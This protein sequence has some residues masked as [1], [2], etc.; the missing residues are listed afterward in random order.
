MLLQRS[1]IST[2]LNDRRSAVAELVE[3]SRGGAST[4]LSNRATFLQTPARTE[5]VP[6]AAAAYPGAAGRL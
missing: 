4:E 3:A 6:R 2:E 1:G 5:P